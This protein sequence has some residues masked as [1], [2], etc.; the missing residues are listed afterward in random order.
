MFIKLHMF[1]NQHDRSSGTA[2]HGTASF[3]AA[4]PFKN[5]KVG[6]IVV[7]ENNATDE[8]TIK[9]IE[10]EDGKLRRE[11]CI[12]NL[13]NSAQE[14]RTVKGSTLQSSYK[15]KG[16]G[17]ASPP[18]PETTEREDVKP[19][20]INVAG[21][22]EFYERKDGRPGSRVLML[23]KTAYVVMEDY[24]TI[25]GK[26]VTAA[27]SATMFLQNAAGAAVRDMTHG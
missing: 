10:S 14:E 12:V 4:V 1:R 7:T 23:D 17:D 18:D 5:W 22:R 15:L 24:N 8:W 9:K 6:Y 20:G 26:V 19:I 13:Q 2:S 25:W 11:N 16:Y 3:S 21:I 27:G